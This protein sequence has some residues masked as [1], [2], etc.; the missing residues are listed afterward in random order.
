MNEE[1]LKHCSNGPVIELAGLTKHYETGAGNV[2]VLLGIDMVVKAGES[3][4]LKG[5]S[6]SGKSTLLH[7]LGAVE[8]HTAGT[9]KVCGVELSTL[10][11]RKQTDFRARNIG[12][13]FQ[14]F[15]LI[16]TLTALENVTA[17]LEPLGGTRALR[18]RA[19]QDALSAVGLSEHAD[20]YPAQLSGGQQ[21]RVAIARALV[22]KPP[23]LLADEPTGNLDT[24]T[25]RQVFGI[26]KKL[27]HETG[28]SMVIATHD[29]VVCEYADRIYHL[30][31]GRLGVE[32]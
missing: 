32:R 29:P 23:L 21:Q 19:A 31:N 22:K 24:A 8:K 5:V 13:V 25:A 12:F 11:F 9:A 7:I 1:L 30:D 17:A 4:A 6:G 28:V 3:V 10:P 16:P 18:E 2:A 26:L 27:Q 20:K 15:N 14:F